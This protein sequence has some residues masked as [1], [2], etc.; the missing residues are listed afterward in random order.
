MTLSSPLLLAD[1]LVD[2]VTRSQ[3]EDG[4][5]LALTLVGMTERLFII[6]EANVCSDRFHQSVYS[7]E[8]GFANCTDIQGKFPWGTQNESRESADSSE[9]KKAK[10]KNK[11]G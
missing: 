2:T 7:G 11:N 1:M 8:L 9:G 10:K 6:D 3:T 5:Q 4:D